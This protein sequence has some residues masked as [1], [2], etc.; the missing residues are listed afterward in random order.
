MTAGGWEKT[1]THNIKKNSFREKKEREKRQEQWR[2]RKELV[3][4]TAGQFV[5]K[6]FK[7]WKEL[8]NVFPG[9]G[10]RGLRG[11][12]ADCLHRQ[13]REHARVRGAW[14]LGSPDKAVSP[15]PRL[16]PYWVSR[17]AG[18]GRGGE[19][20]VRQPGGSLHTRFSMKEARRQR[21]HSVG[22]H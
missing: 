11:P 15:W 6:P 22:L 8:R 21:T 2:G 4:S 12:C 7:L 5:L 1:H 17:G 3:L 19:R 10:D 9:A 14:C 20:D 13:W 18:G 16:Q